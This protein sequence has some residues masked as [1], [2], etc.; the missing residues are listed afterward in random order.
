[1]K[2]DRCEK[3][4]FPKNVWEP[5][6]PPDD[7]A[8]NVS[9]KNPRRTNYS[10]MFSSKVQ[11]LTV[12]SIIYMIRIRFVGDG[13]LIKRYFRCAQYF[14]CL[15][16]AVGCNNRRRTFRNFYGFQSSGL[17]CSTCACSRRNLQQILFLRAHRSYLPIS[18][19]NLSSNF[20]AYGLRWRG[21][22]TCILPINGPVFS[23]IFCV[24]LR[25][26]LWIILVE[27]VPR[28]LCPS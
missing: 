20:L 1:M 10:S 16:F 6:N 24:T 5:S 4:F 15:Y 7:L 13:E 28:L 23:R 22:L 26:F 25:S 9:K 12:C 2:R 8:Q 21:S 11:N 19:W 17:S 14:F 3:C 18:S 27:L